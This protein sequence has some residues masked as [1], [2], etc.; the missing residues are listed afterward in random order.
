MLPNPNPPPS[1]VVLL[2]H[3]RPCFTAPSFT[4]FAVRVTW[5]TRLRVDAALYDL[6]PPRTGRCGR[7]RPRRKGAQLSSLTTLAAQLPAHP[8]AGEPVRADHHRGRVLAETCNGR[9]VSSTFDVLGRRVRRVTPF[10]TDSRWEYDPNDLP[11]SLETAGRTLRFAHD[12]A[13]REVARS[14]DTGVVL[15]QV[16]MPTISC[17]R[18]LL[19]PGWLHQ[20]GR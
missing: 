10:G 16:W 9:T 11:T 5:T 18:I 4:T 1:L 2:S 6:A 7:P 3:L 17:C 13:G 20:R 8:A 12:G 19:Q 15:A 14:L